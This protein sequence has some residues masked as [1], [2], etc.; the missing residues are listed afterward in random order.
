MYCLEVVFCLISLPMTWSGS[1][2]APSSSLQM[3]LQWGEQLIGLRAG[4]PF[5]RTEMG[6][7]NGPAGTLWNSR[8]A[9]AESHTTKGGAPCNS[10]GWGLAGKQLCWKGAGGLGRAQAECPGSK[11]RQQHPR[12]YQQDRSQLL[13]EGVI[14]LYSALLRHHIEQHA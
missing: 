8:R 3:T 6:W 4:L 5:R 7:R 1:W 9:Y 13:R 12:L 2:S 11:D 10:T 14:S